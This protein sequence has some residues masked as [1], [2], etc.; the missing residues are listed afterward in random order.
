MNTL[1]TPTSGDI[2]QRAPVFDDFRFA[3]AWASLGLVPF[4][5]LTWRDTDADQH[6]A[7]SETC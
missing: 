3:C 4:V 5:G 1:Q 2:P 7:E 6:H